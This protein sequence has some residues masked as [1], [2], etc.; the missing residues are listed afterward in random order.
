MTMKKFLPL[1]LLAALLLAGAAGQASAALAVALSSPVQDTPGGQELIFTGT[2][3]NTDMT[4]ALYLNDNQF[5]LTG[6]AAAYLTPD[7]NT[8]FANVPGILAPGASY[9]GELFG[10][11][12]SSTAPPGSYTGNVTFVGGA[13]IFAMGSLAATA[14]TLILPGA[15]NVCDTTATLNDGVNPGGTDVIVSFQ[16]GTTTGYGETTSG[17]DIGAGSVPVFVSAGL[18]G[19][20]PLTTYHYRTVVTST[21]GTVYYADQTFTTTAAIPAGSPWA[22]LVLGVLLA[23]ATSRALTPRRPRS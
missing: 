10:V 4:S 20:Q 22:L 13:N 15:S 17:T 19:L 11:T 12:L 3:T 8:F 16:Y 14:F 7:T 2:L 21:G 23:A 5:A 6:S 18:T 9:T 1:A